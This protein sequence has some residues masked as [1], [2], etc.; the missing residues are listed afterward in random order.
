M[1]KLDGIRRDDGSQNGARWGWVGF[2]GIVDG[3][4]I[5]V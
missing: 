2:G 5:G 4:T 1:V 3:C